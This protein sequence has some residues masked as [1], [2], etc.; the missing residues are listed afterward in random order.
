MPRKPFC[1]SLLVMP[2]PLRAGAFRGKIPRVPK[3]HLSMFLEL[4][5][6]CVLLDTSEN[7]TEVSHFYLN[8]PC[9]ELSATKAW[10]F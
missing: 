8:L 4:S 5:L 2:K 9:I 1:H 6:Y 7:K 3:V 10:D